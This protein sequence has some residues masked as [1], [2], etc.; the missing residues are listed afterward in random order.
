[1]KVVTLKDVPK[2]PVEGAEPI[3]EICPHRAGKG[4]GGRGASE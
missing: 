3:E 1:M 4:N 2:V